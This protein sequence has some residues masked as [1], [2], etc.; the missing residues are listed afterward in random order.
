[1]QLSLRK[2]AIELAH[3]GQQGI[4]GTKARLKTKV[5]WPGLEADVENHFRSCHGCQLVGKATAPEPI[6]STQLTQGNGF[7]ANRQVDG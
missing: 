1:M 2:K 4:T 3:E 6:S 7:I 5:W